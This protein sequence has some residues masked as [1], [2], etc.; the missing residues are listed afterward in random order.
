MRE[1]AVAVLNLDSPVGQKEIAVLNRSNNVRAR[2]QSAPT[3]KHA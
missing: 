2:L 1:L 3:K